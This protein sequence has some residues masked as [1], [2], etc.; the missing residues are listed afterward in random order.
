MYQDKG[1]LLLS[2]YLDEKRAKF[3][4]QLAARLE[5]V[6]KAEKTTMMLCRRSGLVEGYQWMRTGT[7]WD[8]RPIPEE[9]MQSA[10]SAHRS[11]PLPFHSFKRLGPGH[12]RVCGQPIYGAGDY[13]KAAVSKHKRD[14]LRTWHDVCTTTY[15]LMTKPNDFLGVIALRQ[16]GLCAITREPIAPPAREYVSQ[17][18]VDHEVPLY[19]VARDYRDEPWF[20]LLRFWTLPNLRA[21]TNAAHKAKNAAEAQERAGR[22]RGTGQEAML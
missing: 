2:E 15:F 21:I 16:K 20:K 17:A 11:P 9:R 14:S 22:P 6:I 19:R 8:S 1:N 3:L 13:R 5:R 18:D 10:R 7:Y 4:E 12:C